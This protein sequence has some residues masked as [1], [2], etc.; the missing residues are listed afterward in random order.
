VLVFTK[1]TTD[2]AADGADVED[3]D[4][5][6]L[7]PMLMATEDEEKKPAFVTVAENVVFGRVLRKKDTLG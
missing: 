3:T 7:P 5:T 4:P 2:A 6:A 1:A